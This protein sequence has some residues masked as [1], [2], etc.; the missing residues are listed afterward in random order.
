M[1][2]TNRVDPTAAEAASCS[3]M[4]HDEALRTLYFALEEL[5]CHHPNETLTRNV[6]RAARLLFPDYTPPGEEWRVTTELLPR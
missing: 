1:T 3:P 4:T 2:D 5:D 6:V